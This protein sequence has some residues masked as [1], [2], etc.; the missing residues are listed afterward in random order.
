MWDFLKHHTIIRNKE[1]DMIIY[2]E[3]S[4]KQKEIKDVTKFLEDHFTD[5]ELL[6]AV[7]LD[8]STFDSVVEENRCDDCDDKCN[9]DGCD[10]VEAFED[11][12]ELEDTNDYTNTKLVSDFIFG[13]FNVVSFLK[14]LKDYEL[15][16]IFKELNK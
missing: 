6:N 7:D 5:D 8:S 15:R 2:Q 9:E 11:L 10:V 16:N 13:E 12:K 14:E 1:I 3:C 4:E